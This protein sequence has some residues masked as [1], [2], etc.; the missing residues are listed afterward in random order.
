VPL[1]GTAND[2]V[3][4]TEVTWVNNRGGNGVA[5][6]TS[7]WS[8]GSVPLQAGTNVITVTARDAAGNAQ[9]ASVTV[10]FGTASV[11][12]SP[13]PVGPSGTLTSGY[14]TFKWNAVA[15]A[16]GY[17]IW[18]NDSTGS[19]VIQGAYSA[20]QVGCG[21]GIGTCSLTPSI[22][23]SGVGQ[24]WIK[25]YNSSGESPWSAPLGFEVQR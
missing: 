13:S 19:G 23:V 11:P 16:S 24:W 22:P 8:V 20:S 3:G 6:G 21:S 7:S 10:T 12:P 15:S 18:V 17:Q 25:S 1:L 4:V 9:Q 14:I 5:S 2:N